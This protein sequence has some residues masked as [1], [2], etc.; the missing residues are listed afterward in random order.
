[1][2]PRMPA[3]MMAGTIQGPVVWSAVRATPAAKMAPIRYWPSAPMFHT[4]ERKHTA[5]PSAMISKGVALTISSDS[6]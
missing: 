2:P 1:M 6:A 4:L 5:R 3:T